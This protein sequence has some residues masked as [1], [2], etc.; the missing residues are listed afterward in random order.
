MKPRKF[1]HEFREFILRGNVVDLAVAV[2]IG[3]AFTAIINSFITDLVT[4]FLDMIT[5]GYFNIDDLSL[6]LGEG[7]Q[8][9]RFPYG[10]FLAA[11]LNFFIVALVVFLIIRGTNKIALSKPKPSLWECPYCKS[12]INVKAVRC[13][14]CT[15]ILD[16][17]KIPEDVR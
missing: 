15:T 8:A 11:V 5:F 10:Q 1:L 12:S 4:P 6:V 13:P 14:N 2:I 9:K 3:A 16:E 7:A 17:S